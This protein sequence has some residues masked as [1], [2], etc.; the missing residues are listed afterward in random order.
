VIAAFGATLALKQVIHAIRLLRRE[1]WA[2]A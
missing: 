2:P 1:A